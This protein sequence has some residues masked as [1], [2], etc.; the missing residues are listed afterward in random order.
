MKDSPDQAVKRHDSAL[1]DDF[2][3]LGIEFIEFATF[4]KKSASSLQEAL[5]KLG[6]QAVAHHRSKDVVLLRQGDINLILNSEPNSF[7][8][9]FATR[10]GTS[11]CAIALR[12]RNADRIHNAA[13]HAKVQDYSGRIGPDEAFIPAIRA[14]SGSLL[15]LVETE[16]SETIYDRDFQPTE[17]IVSF[18]GNLTRIDHVSQSVFPGMTRKWV[19]FYRR[20]LGFHVLERNTIVDPNGRALSTVLSNEERAIHFIIN[21]PNN[22]GTDCD[23]F[24]RENTGEGVQHL[25]FETPDLFAYLDHVKGLGV[26][27]L[28][29]PNLYYD[30]MLAEGYD[31]ALVEKLRDYRV[32]LDTENGGQFLHAYSQSFNGGIF[33]EFVQ[34]NNHKGFGRHDVTARLMAQ[35]GSVEASEKTDKPVEMPTDMLEFS[36]DT[37]TMLLGTVFSQMTH[38]LMPELMNRSLALH[39]LNVVWLPFVIEPDGLE[40]FVDGVRSLGNLTGFSVATPHKAQIVPLLDELTG[41]ALAV[42]AVNLVRKEADGRLVGDIVDGEGF[43]RG[44]EELRGTVHGACIWL[45]GAGIEGR[46][47]AFAFAEYGVNRIAVSDPDE[48]SARNLVSDLAHAYPAIENSYGQP[49]DMET[50]QI[51]VNATPLGR[52]PEDPMPFNPADLPPETWIADVVA[53]PDM[54]R[55]LFEAARLGH[56][57]CSRRLLLEKQID[58]FAV[59]FGFTEGSSV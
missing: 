21:E 37:D 28:K 26:E 51:A 3:L 8:R 25:A 43:V 23:R 32:M 9:S 10:Y 24:L 7:A 20:L 18:K 39:G 46:A 58:E 42:G 45:V 52:E 13:V 49:L 36:V 12:V 33:F 22:F 17:K 54:T 55:L 4:G 59:F 5:K 30:N 41:R 48:T 1:S 40:R 29:I 53:R 34:R 15:Y 2:G 11:V 14:V 35:K 47:I 57:T 56:K 31:P 19:R 44:V 6:F 50:V 27:V 16:G 38:V